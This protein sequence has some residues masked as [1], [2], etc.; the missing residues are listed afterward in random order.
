MSGVADDRRKSDEAV[1]AHNGAAQ[2][3]SIV[4][5]VLNQLAYTQGCLRS[6][7]ADLRHGVELIV[8][9]NGS[10][11]E[12]RKY[13][14]SLPGIKLVR[15]DTNRGCAPAWNQGAQLAQREWIVILNNDVLL[16]PGW[17]D[18]LVQFAEE[19]PVDIASPAIREG[20]L[21]YPFEDYARQFM[22]RMRDVHRAGVANGVCFM[23]RR[24]VF[25]SVG[26]FDE[27]FRIGQFEDT[28]FF[29]RAQ[30]AGFRLGTTGRAFL[31][32]F[33]SA[34]QSEL[35]QSNAADSYEAQNRSHFRRK[36]NL[37]GWDRFWQ[38]AGRQLRAWRWRARERL[39]H[40]HTLYEKWLR[41]RLRYE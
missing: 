9:D 17:L 21:N 33:G 7:D 27:E 12:T 6:L 29:W 40:R 18:A 31:H 26:N 10:D 22:T 35:R 39:F 11:D 15:N 36:W 4:L 14:A 13:L 24:R 3:V 41:G 19:K 1:E 28:D 8:I 32:H 34:T 2:H 20:L 23:V 30:R 25:E 37:T 38:R 5:P 16:A